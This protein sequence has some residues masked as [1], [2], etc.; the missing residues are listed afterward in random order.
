MVRVPGY[1]LHRPSGRAVV[2]LNGKDYYLG[3]HGSKESRAAYDRKIAEYLATG[4][5]VSYGV[6]S[7]KTTVAMLVADYKEWARG[8]H[9]LAEYNQIRYALR[10]LESYHDLLVSQFTPLKLKAVQATLVKTVGGHGKRLSRK[11]INVMVDRIRI[12]FRWAGSNEIADAGIYQALMT[13]ERL[14]LGRTTAPDHKPVEPVKDHIVEATAKHCTKVVADMIALQMVT[15]MRPAEVCKLTP[16]MIDR[17]D[18]EVW[19]A[20]IRDHKTAWRGKARKVCIGER[21][22]AVLRPYLLR[23][24]DQPCFSPAESKQLMH[25]RRQAA[26]VTPEGVGNSEGTNRVRRPKRIPGNA[27]TTSSYRRAIWRACEK[28]FPLSKTATEAEKLLWK[29]RYQWSPNQI[30]HNVGTKVRKEYGV[31]GAQLVLGHSRV[32]TTQVYAEANAEKYA[33]IARRIG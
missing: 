1:R 5:A 7:K 16:G 31:E 14:K 11:Y 4:Q 18:S 25:E 21:G 32:T 30:R 20:E 29:E 10:H 19:V 23:A 2:T 13:V 17:S 6:S 28:A 26:R 27:Y 8:Y 9:P 3:P 22:Q 24:A 15:G 33:D 12:M